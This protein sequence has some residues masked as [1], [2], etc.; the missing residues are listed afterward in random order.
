M[1][2]Q[3]QGEQKGALSDAEM[4]TIENKQ[5]QSSEEINR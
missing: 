4:E 3:E 1:A 2:P 5:I